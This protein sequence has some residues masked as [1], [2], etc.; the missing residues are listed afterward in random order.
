MIGLLGAALPAVAQSSRTE[1]PNAP[2]WQLAQDSATHF[3]LPDS[4]AKDKIERESPTEQIYPAVRLRETSNKPAYTPLTRGQKY[5]YF[6]QGAKSGQTFVSA[7][8]TAA[9]W[10]AYGDPPYGT[11]WDGFG[12]S[13][14]A[15]LGQRELGFFLQRYAMPV[16]F[17][18]DPRYFAAPKSDNVLQRGIYAASRVALTKADSGRTKMNCAY[19]WGGLTASLVG[20]AYI[21]QR[22]SASVAH[23]FLINMGTDAAYNVAREFWPDLRDKFPTRALR[24]LGDLV[25]GPHG[26]PNPD[27]P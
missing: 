25:I 6:L 11:G 17:R 19:L 24:R 12:K 5:A 14:G 10:H 23:D 15:A 7:A 27:K 22:D 4:A 20:N 9:S 18:E 3:G 26:L 13:Y 2:S 21:R 8:I 16:L 1:L